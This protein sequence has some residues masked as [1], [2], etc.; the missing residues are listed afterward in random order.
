MNWIYIVLRV[1]RGQAVE[2][3]NVCVGILILNGT[4]IA[5]DYD[6]DHWIQLVNICLAKL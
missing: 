4:I 3:C 1:L 6:T 2:S 5:H